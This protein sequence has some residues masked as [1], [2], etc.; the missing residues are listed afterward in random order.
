MHC[1][2]RCSYKYH[3]TF[4]NAKMPSTFPNVNPID[5]CPSLNLRLDIDV[6]D[7]FLHIF[8]S[9]PSPCGYR[10]SNF[11]N[12]KITVIPRPTIPMTVF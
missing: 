2:S 5:L 10:G 11:R 4:G 9:L 7:L 8:H 3:K 1:D 12:E 6:Q